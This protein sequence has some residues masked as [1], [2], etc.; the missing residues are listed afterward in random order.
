M[1]LR[2][3]VSSV[4]ST[5][6]SDMRVKLFL[7]VIL[8]VLATYGALAF[9]DHDPRSNVFCVL[10][11]HNMRP[12]YDEFKVSPHSNFNCH[13]CHGGGISGIIRAMTHELP[14]QILK[15]PSAAEIA[16]RTL[17][18]YEECTQCHKENLLTK[19]EIHRIHLGVARQLSCSACHSRHLVNLIRNDDCTQ[20]HPYDRT[21]RVHAEFH[22]IAQLSLEKG[23][24]NCERCH[25]ITDP[26]HVRY[27]V[28]GA[29]CFDCHG[30]LRPVSIAGRNCVECHSK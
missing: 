2:T 30:A 11:C 10:F 13:V 15:R 25:T 14:S 19:L 20:C 26:A 8:V 12:F 27:A 21:L 7:L 1:S 5:A 18:L 4:L 6:I 22:L 17:H 3:K 29:S 24:I 9:Y 28:Q 16:A 23:I